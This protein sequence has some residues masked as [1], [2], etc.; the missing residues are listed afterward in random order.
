M[1]LAVVFC[2]RIVYVY[3]LAAYEMCCKSSNCGCLVVL[4]LLVGVGV[5]MMVQHELCAP[6]RFGGSGNG[7]VVAVLA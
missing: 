3:E 5:C 2:Y 6:T 7:C 4:L 1:V